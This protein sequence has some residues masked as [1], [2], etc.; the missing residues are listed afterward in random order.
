MFDEMSESA[1][2]SKASLFDWMF[3][4]TVFTVSFRKV[5]VVSVKLFSSSLMMASRLYKLGAS[6]GT[7]VAE[8]SIST[9]ICL[10]GG[11]SD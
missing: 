3:S 1:N 10:T 2:F 11:S 8:H 9:L 6:L 7:I 5:L 4:A